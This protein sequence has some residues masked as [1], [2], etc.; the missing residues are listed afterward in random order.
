MPRVPLVGPQHAVHERCPF[1]RGFRSS[2]PS[3]PR[4]VR[5]RITRSSPVWKSGARVNVRFCWSTS[6][7]GAGAGRATRACF[8]GHRVDAE[9]VRGSNP[10]P[11]TTERQVEWP[12]T[13]RGITGAHAPSRVRRAGQEVHSHRLRSGWC[14]RTSRFGSGAQGA[15]PAP[16]SRTAISANSP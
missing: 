3:G 9:G 10:L 5:E 2:P 8:A 4:E 7:N 12:R 14:S 6:G 1:A 16:R 15:S 13:S 11:P